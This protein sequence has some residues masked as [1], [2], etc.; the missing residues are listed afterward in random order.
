[1][2]LCFFVYLVIFHC[3][4][5]YNYTQLFVEI[6]GDIGLRYLPLDV[7]FFGGV[8]LIKSLGAKTICHR[9]RA[10]LVIELICS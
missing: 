10:G 4:Q 3:V 1:M 9:V 5:N 7:V 6:T 2:S 8:V